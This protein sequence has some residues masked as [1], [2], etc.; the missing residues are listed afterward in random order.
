MRESWLRVDGLIPKF[1]G[2]QDVLPELAAAV[3]FLPQNGRQEADTGRQGH[4][5]PADY[6]SSPIIDGRLLLTEVVSDDRLQLLGVC[7]GVRIRRHESSMPRGESRGTYDAVMAKRLPTVTPGPAIDAG[8]ESIW[9][10]P[11]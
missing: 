8:S 1:D 6:D 10:V 4:Q 5:S 2:S 11:I 7:S 9:L 3:K